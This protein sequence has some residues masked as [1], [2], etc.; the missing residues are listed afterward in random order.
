MRDS[1]LLRYADRYLGAAFC[2]CVSLVR[3]LEARVPN[4]K[5]IRRI[6][7]IELF[8][9][10]AAVMLVPS[11]RHIRAEYPD[12]EIHCLTTSSCA[13]IWESIQVVQPEHLHVIDA[14]SAARLIASV[15]KN[16]LRL[17]REKFDLVIDYELFMRLPA[18]LCGVVR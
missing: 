9:L 8:E 3:S 16:I 14:G 4:V 7:L 15:M 10:G 12:A 5:P 18:L 17:R 1:V 13:T 11:I 2:A 6:L